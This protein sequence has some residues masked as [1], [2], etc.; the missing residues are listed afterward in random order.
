MNLFHTTNYK[1]YNKNID[2]DF[3]ICIISDLHF[4]Y[5]VTNKKLDRIINKLRSEKPDY[6]LFPGDIIDSMDMINNDNEMTRLLSWIK[7]LGKIAVTLI[8]IGN[9]EYFIKDKA[10]NKHF[11][12]D[13]Q[14]KLFKEINNIKNVY[15]LNNSSYEDKFIKVVGYTQSIK[16]YYPDGNSNKSL[17]HPIKEN[18]NIMIDELRELK[19]KIKILD[20]NK[21]NILLAHSPVYLNDLDIRE[22][23][24]DYD[25]YVSG[26]MH[27][28]CVPP[29]LYEL[30]N[31]DRGII[32]PNRELF[33]KAERNTLKNRN[34][35]LIVSGPLTTFQECAGLFQIFNFL[36][37][38]YLTTIEFTNNK[39]Y[40]TD[41]IK[42]KKKYSK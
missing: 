40:D 15:V 30:W 3:K 23:L 34:D 16:Y 10:K 28:G 20:K 41:K 32:T 33:S 27:N 7:E 9:H 21:I 42:I 13:F 18:K 19:N 39:E 22:L 26:H 12:C 2:T 14:D 38:T 36:Y 4:S 25:Y 5:N 29:I 8:S 31:S 11:I 1:L 6:I 37:P 17:L 35:K 24:D